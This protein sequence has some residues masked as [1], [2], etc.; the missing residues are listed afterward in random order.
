M[1]T[2]LPVPEES[3]AFPLSLPLRFRKWRPGIYRLRLLIGATVAAFVDIEI[4]TK[5]LA[6]N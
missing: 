4:R 3:G 6:M 2:A 5:V 1:L